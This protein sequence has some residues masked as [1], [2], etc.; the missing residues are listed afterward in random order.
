MCGT[1]N[2]HL[3]FVVYVARE[4]F[5]VAICACLCR[6]SLGRPTLKLRK[7]EVTCVF[8]FLVRPNFNVRF[9]YPVD[10]VRAQPHR[11]VCGTRAPVVFL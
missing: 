4:P 1:F 2:L 8:F 6:L 7:A 9:F 3:T 11:C 10:G 5:S